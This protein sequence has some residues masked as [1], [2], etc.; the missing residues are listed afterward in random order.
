MTVLAVIGGL[1]LFL[2]IG[3]VRSILA[4]EAKGWV[5]DLGRLLVR[6]AVDQLPLKYQEEK[7]R[8]WEAEFLEQ[9]SKPIS[10]LMW[11][12][13][14]FRSR[15]STAHEMRVVED[16]TTSP[17]EVESIAFSSDE[18]PPYLRSLIDGF[19][20]Y[21]WQHI[22]SA[23]QDATLG[24]VD[25]RINAATAQFFTVIDKARAISRAP[26]PRFQQSP[27][28]YV[29]NEIYVPE[30]PKLRPGFYIYSSLRQEVVPP[31]ESWPVRLLR[32]FLALDSR[33]RWIAAGAV[34][35]LVTGMPVWLLLGT[36]A[37]V[38]SIAVATPIRRVAILISLGAFVLYASYLWPLAMQRGFIG[39]EEGRIIGWTLLSV[40]TV[41]LFAP[42]GMAR[43]L[44][45]YLR[46]P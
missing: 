14:L 2:I 24:Q 22:A 15:H 25:E 32:N 28:S 6:R 30:P 13:R 39:F 33:F 38:L 46:R 8:E 40:W 42:I 19:H 41:A 9:A 43:K 26:L 4:D 29:W 35:L 21:G 16:S 37:G 23:M 3:I 12:W 7:R 27:G 1:L 5:R 18:M 45:R 34:T 20:A 10:S 31:K 36:L 44:S 11:S 17:I